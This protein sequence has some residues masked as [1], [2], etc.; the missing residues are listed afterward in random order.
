M[1]TPKKRRRALTDADHL[2]IR[3]RRKAHPTAQQNELADWFSKETGHEVNQGMI[4]KVPGAQYDTS[5]LLTLR[6]IRRF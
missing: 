5:T 1:E 3:K 4:S 6:Q 2:L